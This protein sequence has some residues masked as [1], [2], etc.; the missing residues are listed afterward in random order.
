MK[1][2]TRFCRNPHKKKTPS[3]SSLK[4]AYAPSSS[5]L[6]HSFFFIL[7]QQY[8]TFSPLLKRKQNQTETNTDTKAKPRT[9]ILHTKL[10]I[11]ARTQR[12][13]DSYTMQQ[14]NGF[15]NMIS[16]T[17]QIIDQIK[18]KKMTIPGKMNDLM[19]ITLTRARSNTR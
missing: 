13:I 14:Q 18:R 5:L 7:T 3:S 16:S 10:K 6:N 17:T 2:Y 9:Q 12:T 1:Q 19:R 11:D 8:A 4:H 15:E